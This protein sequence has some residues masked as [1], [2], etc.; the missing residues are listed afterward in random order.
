IGIQ[1]N[2][3][4]VAGGNAVTITGAGFGPDTTVTIGGVPLGNPTVSGATTITGT[5]PPAP[6]GV[7]AA[8]DVIATSS[9]GTATLARAFQY[10]TVISSVVPSHGPAAGGTF[11]TIRGGGFL[12]GTTVLVAG[13]PLANLQIVDPNTITGIV[14]TAAG[15]AS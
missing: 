13:V 2:A 7:P 11:V 8:V 15:Q 12:A 10:G 4:P 14:A 3:G 5:L 9:S 6:G 1:P